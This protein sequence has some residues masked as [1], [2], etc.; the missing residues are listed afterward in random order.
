[1]L[2]LITKP[3]ILDIGSD[4]E[5]AFVS[6]TCNKDI[7]FRLGWHMLK[8]RDYQIQNASSSECDAAEQSF[9]RSGV[10]VIVSAKS[11][12]VQMLKSRLSSLLKDQILWQLPS[13]IGGVNEVSPLG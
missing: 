10:W 3:D 6:L 11:L 9:F 2:G 12:G 8:N 1:M 7:R 4:N 13:L 5:A